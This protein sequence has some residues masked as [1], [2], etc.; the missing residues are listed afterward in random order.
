MLMRFLSAMLIC[1]MTYTCAHEVMYHEGKADAV[2]TV[3][4]HAGPEH[5]HEGHGHIDHDH[6]RE[7]DHDSDH[8]DDDSHDHQLRILI[9]KKDPSTQW[10]VLSS[11]S[12]IVSFLA[13][14][15]ADFVLASGLYHSTSQ[16]F[17]QPLPG[18]L[19][20]HVLRL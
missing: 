3:F 6:P 12:G 7:A 8:H 20:A 16:R 19:C 18:Y 4:S 17:E 11:H 15:A 14:D 5:H 2:S 10:R 1:T 9:A 13:S